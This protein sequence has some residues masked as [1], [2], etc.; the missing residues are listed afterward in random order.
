[1]ILHYCRRVFLSNDIGLWVS[2]NEVVCA[3]HLP[4]FIT[5]I[6][7]WKLQIVILF[8]VKFSPS[9]WLIIFFRYKHF[10]E[11]HLLRNPH[12]PCT[13]TRGTKL[14][15]QRIEKSCGFMFLNKSYIYPHKGNAFPEYSLRPGLFDEKGSSF[16]QFFFTII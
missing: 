4:Y 14:L 16:L 10:S 8:I 1:M 7:F 11:N 2:P 3:S 15:T 6:K 9:S 5:Q 13:I 12:L